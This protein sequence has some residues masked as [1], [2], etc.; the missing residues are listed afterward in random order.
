MKKNTVN[1]KVFKTFWI[2]KVFDYIHCPKIIISLLLTT[3][4]LFIIYIPFI[5]KRY[6]VFLHYNS[7]MWIGVISGI[8]WI[9]LSPYLIYIFIEKTSNLEYSFF[10]KAKNKFLLNDLTRIDLLVILWMGLII[11]AIILDVNY[12][13]RFGIYGFKDP[14]FYLFILSIIYVLYYT[15][16]GIKAVIFFILS[17]IDITTKGLLAIDLFNPDGN[18][19]VKQVKKIIFTTGRLFATGTLFIPILFDYIFYT[20]NISVKAILYFCIL[21]FTVLV[22]LVFLIPFILLYKYVDKFKKIYLN[23]LLLKYKNMAKQNFTKKNSILIEKELEALNLYNHINIVKEVRICK[24]DFNMVIEIFGAIIIPL[25][26]LSINIQDIINTMN[27]FI[28]TI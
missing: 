4:P 28:N 22:V 13:I 3:V 6:N 12:L 7:R 9:S 10:Y 23:N 24:L 25:F 8:I 1:Q 21:L 2:K 19:G 5:F 18:G 11:G 17:V 16:I 14:Y 26:G 27:T 15:S 20:Q